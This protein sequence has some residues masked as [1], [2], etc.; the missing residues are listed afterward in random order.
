MPQDVH[1]SGA[2]LLRQLFIVPIRTGKGPAWANSLF[3]DNAEYGLGMFLGVKQIRENIECTLISL[4]RLD[5]PAE[6]KAAAEEW[7]ASMDDGEASK[8]ASRTYD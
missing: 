2:A 1:P 7:I 8:K 3:E 6:L 4:L 5:V